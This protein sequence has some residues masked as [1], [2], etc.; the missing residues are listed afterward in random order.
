M[1][2]RLR[3]FLKKRYVLA[4]GVCTLKV[5]TVGVKAR[6]CV[7]NAFEFHKISS[8]DGEEPVLELF[9]KTIRPG[10]VVLDIGANI[11]LYTLSAALTGGRSAEVIAVEPVKAW[12]D[13]LCRNIKLNKLENVRAYCI[14]FADEDTVKEVNLKSIPGSGMGS[15]LC[16]YREQI[17]AA[18]L[19]TSLVK[20]VKGDNFLAQQNIRHPNIMKID[21]EGA[22]LQVLRGLKDSISRPECRCI[23]CE[24]HPKLLDEKTADLHRL[25]ENYGF[26]IEQLQ[27]RGNEYHILA[28]RQ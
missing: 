26:K 11:G 9:L 12:Y 14:G 20:L 7:E 15:V 3:A 24:V 28:R 5:E 16:K 23:F 4:R 1:F 18:N 17:P 8:K 25:L 22:E 2:R 27:C 13:Q 19:E 10:D 21:V 6:L